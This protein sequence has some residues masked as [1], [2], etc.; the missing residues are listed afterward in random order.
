MADKG[1][2]NSL[3]Y[4]FQ[5]YLELIRFPLFPIPIVSTLPGVVL[6]GGGTISW[7]GYVALTIALM[8]YFSG[9][10]KND[11]FHRK[12]DAM[13][14]PAKPIPS[15]RVSPKFAF[16]FASMVYIVCL[17]LSFIL[18]YRAGLIVVLLIMISHLYN[19][20]FKGKGILGSIILPLGIA[21]MSIFGSLSVSGKVAGMVW[22][23]FAAIFLYDFSAHIATTFKDIDQDRR[24][25]IVTT[26]IQIGIRPALILSTI[27]M[28]SAFV[29]ISLPYALGKAQPY[30]LIWAGVS[31]GTVIISRLPL[32]ANQTQE[33]GYM[34]LK[35]S[36]AGAIALYP[37]LM[38][39]VFPIVN[40]GLLILT[41]Y[42]I[43]AILLEVTSQRV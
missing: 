30:Y 2:G 24:V 15:G 3:K 43:S 16:I 37:C 1:E 38:G 34:A 32:L 36:M 22:Y 33:N 5:A 40:C 11:Y 17:I 20:I 18:N 35:G 42:L 21:T 13:V 31:L 8:G 6:A 27:A 29:V 23:S 9:M 4:K 19:A 39:V 26:P 41:L 14:N 12:T 10:M 25:G 28:L 7:K